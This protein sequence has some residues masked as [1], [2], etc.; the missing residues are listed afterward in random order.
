MSSDDIGVPSAEE[1]NWQMA[2]LITGAGLLGSHVA[3]PPVKR[4]EP[5]WLYDMKLDECAA[6]LTEHSNEARP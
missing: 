6:Y 1:I 3:H 2:T 4:R 5:T